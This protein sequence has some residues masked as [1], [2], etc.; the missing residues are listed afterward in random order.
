M[1]EG[2][3]VVLRENLM[4]TQD[5]MECLHNFQQSSQPPVSLDEMSNMDKSFT[6]FIR[7]F[8]EGT[9]SHLNTPIYWWMCVQT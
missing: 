3:G 9:N 2:E 5:T 8:S 7:D 6:A 1:G 4:Q